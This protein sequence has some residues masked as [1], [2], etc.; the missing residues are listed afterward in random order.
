MMEIKIDFDWHTHEETIKDAINAE[1]EHQVR[2]EVKKQM[3]DVRDI[4]GK[5]I[6]ERKGEIA[7]SILGKM[8][9]EK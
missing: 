9:G 1:I 5:K 7:E 3:K 2:C 4:V 6:N 8:F